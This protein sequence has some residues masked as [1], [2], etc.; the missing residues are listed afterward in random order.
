MDTNI[1]QV[2]SMRMRGTCGMTPQAYIPLK[3]TWCHFLTLAFLSLSQMN[4]IGALTSV[5]SECS[6]G[7]EW[8]LETAV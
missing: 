5:L 6:A 8:H 1:T 7:K 2:T 3:Q 4:N